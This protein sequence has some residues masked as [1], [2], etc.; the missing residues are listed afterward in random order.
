MMCLSPP[1]LQALDSAPYI[2]L[3]RSIDP[4]Q[5]QPYEVIN[6]Y[7]IPMLDLLPAFG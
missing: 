3:R 7:R 6:S 2:A 5:L 4:L 1:G